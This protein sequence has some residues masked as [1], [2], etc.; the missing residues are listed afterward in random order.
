MGKGFPLVWKLVIVVE[1]RI[2]Y[3]KGSELESE[4][5]LL[6]PEVTDAPGSLQNRNQRTS[7]A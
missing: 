6:T 5:V 2:K 3:P 4:W 7:K 1:L